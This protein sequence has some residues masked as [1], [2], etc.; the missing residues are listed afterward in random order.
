LGACPK[1]KNIADFALEQ[2]RKLDASSAKRKVMLAKRRRKKKDDI[3]T[4]KE[5]DG[6]MDEKTVS[7][8]EKE[9][10]A[11]E[12]PRAQQASVNSHD[13]KSVSGENEK[14]DPDP[15][16]RD[17]RARPQRQGMAV[18]D[19]ADVGHSADVMPRA[20]IFGHDTEFQQ[21]EADSTATSP[22]KEKCST[23]PSPRHSNEDKQ[24]ANQQSPNHSKSAAKDSDEE[25]EKSKTRPRPSAS[26][27]KG[28]RCWL[29][30]RRVSIKR[31]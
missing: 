12:E 27:R 31:L 3:G 9:D 20:G 30:L 1:D 14:Q 2:I 24:S 23:S 25:A 6:K 22:A 28:R 7:I 15:E 16:G 8:R 29:S 17:L 13:E 26:L 10:A 4:G 18:S 5:S 11:R 19:T 21:P